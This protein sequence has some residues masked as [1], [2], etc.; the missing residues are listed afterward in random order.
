MRTDAH[1]PAIGEHQEGDTCVCVCFAR[2]LL[3]L[4]LAARTFVVICLYAFGWPKRSAD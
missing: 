2:P 4:V 1:F 3:A